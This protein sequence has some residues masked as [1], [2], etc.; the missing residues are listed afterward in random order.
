MAG[1]VEERAEMKTIWKF[2]LVITGMQPVRLPQGAEILSVQIQH[3]IACLWALVDSDAEIEETTL[4]IFGTGHPVDEGLRLEFIATI[5]TLGGD[6]IW[7][8]FKEI[9]KAEPA[10]DAEIHQQESRKD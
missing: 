5:P 7:H 9:E 4:R 10:K 2:P 8:V 6:L 3:G 1:K